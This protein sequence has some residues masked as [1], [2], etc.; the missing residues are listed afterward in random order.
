[1]IVFERPTRAR[2]SNLRPRN[3]VPIEQFDLET[4]RTRAK[5]LRVKSGAIHQLHLADARY[6]VNREQ[7]FENDVALRFLA[8]FTARAILRRFVFFQIACRQRPEPLPRF[9]RAPAEKEPVSIRNNRSHND[10]WIC[11]V[12]VA[13]VATHKTFRRIS[14]GNAANETWM[15]RRWCGAMCGH[16]RNSAQHR[17]K[18]KAQNRIFALQMQAQT[19]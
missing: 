19:R 14:F 6:G 12:D 10:F 18:T 15:E 5:S 2:E 16:A 1:M 4:F 8:G 13:A 11:V 3:I 7:S 9:D 17:F